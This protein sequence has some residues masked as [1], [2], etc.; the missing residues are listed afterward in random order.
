MKQTGKRYAELNADMQS[1]KQKIIAIVLIT[2]LLVVLVMEA[3]LS[4]FSDIVIS[5]TNT[6]L[7][8]VNITTSN[9][10][11]EEQDTIPEESPITFIPGVPGVQYWTLGDVNNFRWTVTNAGRSN[12]RLTNTLRIAWDMDVLE[13]LSTLNVVFVYPATMSDAAIRSD[14]ENNNAGNALN[15]SILTE[16]DFEFQNDDE[17]RG[18]EFT[19]EDI[20]SINHVYLSGN[21]ETMGRNKPCTY[22]PY[23]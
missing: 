23:V 1:Y 2:V 10:E 3:A 5:A 8:N 22:K 7:G 21:V 17:R 6:V 11:I 16:T 14:I 12:V 4:F 15:S 19:L 18:I 20:S 13:H 9:V